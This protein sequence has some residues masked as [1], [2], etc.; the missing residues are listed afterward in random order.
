MA[1]V[2]HIPGTIDRLLAHPLVITKAVPTPD[3]WQKQFV[4][5]QPLHLEIGSGRGRFIYEA[6]KRHPELNFLALD[7]EPEIIME[8]ID[9]YAGLDDFSENVRFMSA[10]ARHLAKILPPASV[11]QLYLHFS[12]PW[13]KTRHAK[14]R[15][16][17]P[18]FL[19]VYQKIL[20]PEGTLL[21]KT[22]HIDFYHWS[23]T[24]LMECGWQLLS[25]TADLY[26]DLP[27]NNIATEYER[28]F[29]KKGTPIHQILAQPPKNA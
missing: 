24:T 21:F 16:T 23:R 13:P 18:D 9:T 26:A 6:A 10:D 29:Q 14:R 27:A 1:R 2:R 19:A 22:D 11:T 20:H 17:A 25:D 4:C 15:L 5:K 8:A 7:V 3:F 12:D 28:K